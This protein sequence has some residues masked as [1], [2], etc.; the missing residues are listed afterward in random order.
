MQ[1]RAGRSYQPIQ[2][3]TDNDNTACRIKQT[4]AHVGQG[5]EAGQEV[6]LA[7]VTLSI[8]ED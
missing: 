2:A 6:P 5:R 8:P 7:R 1:A 4:L 3:A